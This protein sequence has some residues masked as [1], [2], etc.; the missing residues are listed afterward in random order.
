MSEPYDPTPKERFWAAIGA[1]TIGT[2]L[3]LFIG[4]VFPVKE[5]LSTGLV[6]IHCM[7]YCAFT[8]LLIG[9]ALAVWARRKCIDMDLC[10]D[11]A[12]FTLL[13]FDIPIVLL[14]VCQQGGLTRSMFVS[15]FFLIPVAYLSVERTKKRHRA[16][17]VVLSIVACL[18]VSCFVSQSMPRDSL[19]LLGLVTIP[20]TDFSTLVPG[21]YAT[22][23]LI[24]S[25]ISLFT[26]FVQ[27][28]IFKFLDVKPL[29][30]RIAKQEDSEEIWRI[31][32][33]AVRE[34]SDSHYT[35][36][37]IKVWADAEKPEHFKESI[38]NNEFYVAEEN[39]SVIGFGILTRNGGIEGIYV[40]PDVVRRGVGKEI[41]KKLEGR[42]RELDLTTLHLDSSLNA[43]P[44]Y[45]RAG[46]EQQQQQAKHSLASG[47]EMACVRMIKEL[48][49]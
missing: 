41:L 7:A 33:S 1:Q 27:W 4:N 28:G 2:L 20:V 24:V 30:I 44:F 17:L 35:A 26:P 36:Q 37:E 21:R 8:A 15:L 23:T 18:F 34:I 43:V 19:N 39:G 12:I 45:E 40:K 14:L 9:L 46:Y 10:A 25:S 49:P 11:K 47:D 3:L 22:A 5:E 16:Y 38:R 13:C 32:T 42:A 29:I 48:K 6:W 31:H